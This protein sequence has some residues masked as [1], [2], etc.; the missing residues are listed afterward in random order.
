MCKDRKLTMLKSTLS[1]HAF[2]PNSISEASWK[3]LHLQIDTSRYALFPDAVNISCN[4]S[5]G[6]INICNGS[7]LCIPIVV[8]VEGR[9]C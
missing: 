5:N 8:G 7:S 1:K 6:L 9:I 3:V 2:C 4:D